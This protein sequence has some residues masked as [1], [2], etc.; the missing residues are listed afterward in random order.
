MVFY[1]IFSAV[2]AGFRNRKIRN[3]T[4]KHRRNICREWL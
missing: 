4:W 3:N 2:L 1:L